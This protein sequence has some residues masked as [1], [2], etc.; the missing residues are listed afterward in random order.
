MQLGISPHS[1]IEVPLSFFPSALGPGNHNAEITFTSEQVSRLQSLPF[2]YLIYLFCDFI[3]CIYLFSTDNR[4]EISVPISLLLLQNLPLLVERV[5][6]LLSTDNRFEISL[7][8]WLL[9]QN[10][11]LLVER[12]SLCSLRIN[13]S[14]LVSQF[15]YCYKICTY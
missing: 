2:I 3:F 10:L 9:L 1:G 8:I 14:K 5:F 15:R 12:V 4:F 11:P 7:S 6:A 13:A